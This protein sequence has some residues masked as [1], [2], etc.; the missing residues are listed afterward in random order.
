VLTAPSIL[1]A[2]S[3]LRVSNVGAQPVIEFL[4][5]LLNSLVRD[6]DPAD[7]RHLDM[8]VPVN[9]HRFGRVLIEFGARYLQFVIRAEKVGRVHL[10]FAIGLRLESPDRRVLSGRCGGERTECQVDPGDGADPHAR[11]PTSC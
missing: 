11:A 3:D 5:R 10:A 7:Q 6:V 8:A 4:L 9:P 2:D 1:D